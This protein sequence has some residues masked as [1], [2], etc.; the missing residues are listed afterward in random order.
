MPGWPSLKENLFNANRRL[1]SSVKP[2]CQKQIFSP[3]ADIK[4]FSWKRLGQSLADYLHA[5]DNS[6]F[7]ILSGQL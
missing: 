1:I 7:E 3:K 2:L 4:L 6:L 5:L